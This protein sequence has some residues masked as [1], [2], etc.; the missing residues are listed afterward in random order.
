MVKLFNTLTRQVEEFKP[1]DPP[2][3]GFYACGPTVYQYAHIGNL[4]TYI[5]ED[6][7]RRTLEFNGYQVKHVVNI[8]DVGHLTSDADTGDDKVE[9]SAKNSGQS[10]WAIAE[11]YTAAF[12]EDIKK[13]NILTPTVLPKA[14]D[15]IPEQIDLIKKLEAKGFTYQTADGLYFDVSKFPSYGKLAKLNLAGQR[16]G[17]RVEENTA[18]KNP[19]DFAL[20]KFSPKGEK[21]QMEW[22]S[23][24]GVGF[25]GWHIECSAMSTKYLG[26]PFDIHAGGVDHIPTHHTA[27]VAQSEAASGKPLANYFV[28][29]EFLVWQ[30]GK[31]SSRSQAHFLHSAAAESKSASKMSKSLGNIVTLTKLS[32]QGYDP[33]SYRY[34]VLTAH[35][36]SKLNFSFEAL[37]AAG[38]ALRSLRE[39][40]SSLPTPSQ[41]NSEFEAKFKEAIG[42][43]LDTPKVL[44]VIWELVKSDLPAEIK[45]ATLFR[46]DQVLGLGL[47]SAVAKIGTTAKKL[48]A[49]RE[50]ARTKKDYARADLLRSQL[51]ELG[52]VLRDTKSGPEWFKKS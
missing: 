7:L 8:T 27:E 10:A 28:H 46:F 43:D 40:V 13:L 24:W 2:E 29:G 14:T 34:L 15:H 12:M 4:R 1:I 3:V 6:I 41:V 48:I 39:V 22:Q 26:Q 19:Y 5:F 25:P 42:N 35:Y 36:R 32:E 16:A 9:K 11:K 49:E 33:L 17:A 18:K 50:E 21:R 52:Y 51:E 23:P 30:T 45:A 44:A 37:S 20:W 38:E 31:M 47:E